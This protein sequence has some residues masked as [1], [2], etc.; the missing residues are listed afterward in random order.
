MPV[1]TKQ[2]GSARQIINIIIHRENV[3]VHDL[4]YRE[5]L[6]IALLCS[7]DSQ[8]ARTLSDRAVRCACSACWLVPAMNVTLCVRE[9]VFSVFS[10]SDSVMRPARESETETE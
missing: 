6:C 5:P 10:V 8:T 1:T 7:L 4:P 2:E 9:N 3:G